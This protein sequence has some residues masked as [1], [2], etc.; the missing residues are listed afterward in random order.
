MTKFYIT[1]AIDYVNSDPHIGHSY[2]KIVADV[3]ARWHKLKGEDVFFLT[4]TD[5]HGIKIF[6]AAE[7]EK[8]KPKE[9]VD[10]Y[11]K[12]FKNAWKALNINYDRF[13]RTTDKDH[14]ELVQKF[15]KEMY[16]KGDI[17]KGTYEGYYCVGCEKYITEKDLV[18]GKCPFHPNKKIEWLKEES[19]F[20]KLSKYQDRLLKL[21][22]N[23]PE[24]ILPKTKRNEIINRV[25]EGLKD[26]S[27]SRTSF[28][29]GI[30]FPLDE[31][32]VTYVW[33]EALLNY[34]TALGWP[35]GEKFK[36]YWP[37]DVE[38]LGVDNSWFH[39]VI[40]P[41]I[42][43]SAGIKP[44][45]TIFVHGFLTFN[46]QKIS[47][48]LGNSINPISLVKKYGADAVRYYLI[49]HIPFGEDGDFSEDAL[50][51]RIN[52]E[53]VNVLGN[54][55]SRTLTI[56][57]KF[58]GKIEGKAELKLDLK[59]INKLIDKYELHNALNEIWS[60][61]KK[62]NQ[63]INAKEPW[64][65]KDKELGNVL[66]NLLES[67]RIISILIS[68]FIPETSEKINK[69]LGVK[70]GL[71]KDCVFKKFDGKIKKGEHLFKRV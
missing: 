1:T 19:Y 28:P 61:V 67:L 62:V 56:A 63:Y 22:R 60:F 34:I 13:I 39:C 66:Y 18:N 52:G 15:I 44:A 4:G 40:W 21:Y 65:L 17:Y 46:G 36:K 14:K 37:A 2:Q 20:F 47:K 26:L 38:L 27:I 23:H 35:N 10:K 50:V 31:K 3:L 51:K 5:E 70:K 6:R 25:K 71:L 42:L 9:F 43:Y 53:L 32:H 54:L 59:K 69:Q 55:V 41:A 8:I 45:K 33:Y 57:S 16:K 58:K 49:R 12:K 11:A 29:W 64:K 30:P 24:Y 7:K 68:S 48:S